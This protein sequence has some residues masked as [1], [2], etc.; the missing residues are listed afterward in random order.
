[1]DGGSF[2]GTD[3][4]SGRRM[5]P[6]ELKRRLR[7]CGAT[8]ALVASI[9]ALQYE[10]GQG[11]AET[12]R[13]CA[14]DPSFVPM[15]VAAPM[16]YLG[17][18]GPLRAQG[19]RAVGVFP[20]WPG[21]GGDFDDL[22]LRHIAEA[23]IAQNLP[24]F[25]GLSQRTDFA[26]VARNLAPTGARLALRWM[27]GS[28]YAALAEAMA[29][30]RACPNVLIDA[31]MA[32]QT[33]GVELL[34]RT[35][36]A[37]RLFI[38]ANAPYAYEACPYFLVQ[39]ARIAEADRQMILDGTLAHLLDLPAEKQAPPT[40]YAELIA[41]PKIDTL[42]NIGSFDTIEPEADD[43]SVAESVGRFHT[44]IAILS[45][46]RAIFDDMEAGNMETAAFLDRCPEARGLIAVNPMATDASHAE[47]D[48]YA[49]DP[50]F[51]GVKTIQDDAH[52]LGL[53]DARYAPILE[54]I[55][56]MPGWTVMAH[57]TG[58]G[59]AARRH[60][61]ITFVSEHGTWR[62]KENADI[63]NMMFDLCTSTP[64]VA[65]TDIPDLIGRVGV[66]RVLY[67]SDAPLM[68]PAFTL[69]KLASLELEPGHLRAILRDNALRAFPRLRL[70][71]R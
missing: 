37:D 4:A 64:L 51:I 22:A 27:R 53:D 34:V 16:A 36:G 67:A 49:G 54:R 28:G 50:R 66:E 7:R 71:A 31:G 24:L 3:R 39:S 19:F 29:V 6:D 13:L 15:A 61:R 42:Y 26:K 46:M 20:H 33:G 70:N 58:L 62:H 30:A 65:Q 2:F 63:P 48:R 17:D 10:A 43:A 14:E 38:A 41:A 60:P 69:G 32:P 45:S 1:M 35:F 5:P 68:S 57:P 23:A 11:N 8:R 25:L 55:G 21:H 52:G 9:T 47:I 12:L 40:G 44:E 18:I 56:R 59:A